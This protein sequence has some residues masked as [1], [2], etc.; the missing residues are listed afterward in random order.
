MHQANQD[1]GRREEPLDSGEPYIVVPIV[2][3]KSDVKA[4][5][6]NGSCRLYK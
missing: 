5:G 1:L 2:T 3:L 6:G 4:S